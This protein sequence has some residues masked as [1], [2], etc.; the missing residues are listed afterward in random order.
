MIS[1][2]IGCPLLTVVARPAVDDQLGQ[3]P[4][5]LQPP[6]E[7]ERL[8]TSTAAVPA[9]GSARSIQTRIS[10]GSFT[11]PEAFTAGARLFGDGKSGG[12]RSQVI[13][14]RGSGV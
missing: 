7:G 6:L 9:S 5:Q 14:A 13:G 3:H 10:T 8:G 1:S 11:S 12:Q 2:R 4:E